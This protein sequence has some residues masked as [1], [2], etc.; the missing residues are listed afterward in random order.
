MSQQPLVNL[1][2]SFCGKS[3]REVKKLIA[4]PKVFICDECIGLCNDII[5][6]EVDR[7]TESLG[8]VRRVILARMERQDLT[9]TRLVESV[10]RNADLLPPDVL[11]AATE[12][13]LAS[14]RFRQVVSTSIP[15][16]AG[17]GSPS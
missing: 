17:Q 6:E 9:L 1:N 16:P 3:Q 12:L 10:R 11:E 2:C 8:E 5:A 4:G 13:D 14:A 15:P 7:H